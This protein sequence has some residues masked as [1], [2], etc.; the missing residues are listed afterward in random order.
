MQRYVNEFVFRLNQKN[1]DKSTMGT[2]E[3]V[4]NNSIGRRLTYEELI[5]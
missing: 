4:L 3:D 2:V 1:E 5:R